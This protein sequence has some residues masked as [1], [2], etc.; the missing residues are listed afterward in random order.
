MIALTPLSLRGV[1][2]WAAG[3]ASVLRFTLL[4]YGVVGV[5]LPFVGIEAIDLILTACGLA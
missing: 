2:Y 1:S 5:V 3:A 4:L